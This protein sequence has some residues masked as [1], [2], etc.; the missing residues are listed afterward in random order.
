L[1]ASHAGARTD[2]DKNVHVPFFDGNNYWKK[3]LPRSQALLWCVAFTEGCL[4]ILAA[5]R[6]RVNGLKFVRRSA[7]VATTTLKTIPCSAGWFAK[8]ADF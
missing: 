6:K 8:E 1:S 7:P 4:G 2:A 3:E 5:G